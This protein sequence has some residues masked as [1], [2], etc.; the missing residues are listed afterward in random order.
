ML[1]ISTELGPNGF[2]FSK[3]KKA[4]FDYAMKKNFHQTSKSLL[5]Y[6][7]KKFFS[8]FLADTFHQNVRF[9]PEQNYIAKYPVGPRHV[10]KSN[11]WMHLFKESIKNRLISI[12][13]AQSIK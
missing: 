9:L 11:I 5:P 1:K 2:C 7:F 3:K 4:I 10:K 6:P 8:D 13:T 12:N